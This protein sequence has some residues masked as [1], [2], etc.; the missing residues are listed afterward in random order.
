MI[1]II[2]QNRSELTSHSVII[3][4]KVNSLLKCTSSHLK[5]KNIFP[6]SWFVRYVARS[7]DTVF[8]NVCNSDNCFFIPAWSKSKLLNCRTRNNDVQKTWKCTEVSFVSLIKPYHTIH[9]ASET[10]KR[11]HFI[12]HE[13]QNGRKQITHSL[14]VTEI[15]IIHDVRHQNMV[16]HFQIRIVVSGVKG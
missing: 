1:N 9:E 15:K 3:F 14:N 10:P 8:N 5:Q 11:I 7:G 4:S 12:T 6:E 2:H 13:E 16:Q